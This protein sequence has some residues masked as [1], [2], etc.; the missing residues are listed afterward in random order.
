MPSKV[1]TGSLTFTSLRPPNLSKCT[2]LEL[3]E[4]FQNSYDLNESLYSA[5]NDDSVFYKCPDRLRLPLIFYYGHTAAVYTN[6]LM[7]AGLI[8]TRINLEMETVFETGVDE[9]SWDDT[10]NYRMGGS[11]RWPSLADVISYRRK[12]REVILRVIEDTPLQLPINMDSPWWALCMGM[13]HDRIHLET[14]SVLIRQLPVSMVTKPDGWTYAPAKHGGGI[15]FNP[16][17]LVG[18]HEDVSYGKPEDFPSYG[19]DVEYGE[20]HCNIVTP[21]QAS[22]YLITNKE[23]LE[24]VNSGGY[25]NRAWWTDEGY[26]WKNYRQVSHPTFWVC[27]QGCPSGCGGDLSEHSH[28]VADH[29]HIINLNGNCLSNGTASP[30]TINRNKYRYRAM[31]DNIEMPWDWPV[32]VNYH[33]AKAYCA[34]KGPEYRLPAEVEHNIMRGEQKDPS[35]GISADIIFQDKLVAN[36]NLLYG[37]STPVNMYSPSSEGFHDVFG[38]VWEWTEDHF[39]GLPGSEPHWL[40]DD[41]STPCYDGR[42]NIIM[43]GS[44]I[45]TGDEASRF[46]RFAFRRHFFQHLGFRTAKTI[47]ANVEPRLSAR[48]VNTEVYVVGAGVRETNNNNSLLNKVSVDLVPTTNKQY[49]YDTQPALYGIIELEFGYRDSYTV[50]AAKMAAHCMS[51]YKCDSTSV[52]HVGAGV[53]SA[54]LELSKSFDKVLAVEYSGRLVD[55]GERLLKQG[56]LSYIG[57]E[58]GPTLVSIDETSNPK[59]ITYKQFTWLP[60]EIGSHDVVLLTFLDRVNNPKAWLVRLWE[61]TLSSG[62]MVVVSRDG[63]NADKLENIIGNRMRL[64]SRDVMRFTSNSGAST[65]D[66]SVWRRRDLM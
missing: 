48:L 49:L 1:L 45:S 37:S 52:L 31:F 65:A 20:V 11:F 15:K 24:F 17:L 27:E 7:L 9:M 59:K 54:A 51:R 35:I 30:T 16:M 44:W 34:W 2:K 26:E 10:E 3:R 56:E 36:M 61:V 8:N 41:F 6:K 58:T 55:V 50:M 43:G 29:D 28:C 5:L 39:N 32:E 13:E 66:V 23:Y 60:N 14:S 63:W 25:D 38:N 4:Y 33:E 42:H 18:P 57:A 40:Y 19:W 47:I 53:G 46:A 21:F 12:V 62:I 22:K 64:L